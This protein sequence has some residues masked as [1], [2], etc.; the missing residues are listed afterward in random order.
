MASAYGQSSLGPENNHFWNVYEI[1]HS[2]S[3]LADYGT[4]LKFRKFRNER[5]IFFLTKSIGWKILEK[6][7]LYFCYTLRIIYSVFLKDIQFSY[8]L[9]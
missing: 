3:G 5:L 6:F 8:V 7:C 9:E 4:E 1:R 2:I